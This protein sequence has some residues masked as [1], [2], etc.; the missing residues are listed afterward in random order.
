MSSQEQQEHIENVEYLRG[1][2]QTEIEERS[3]LENFGRMCMNYKPDE[4]PFGFLKR[5]DEFNR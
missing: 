4:S 1:L 2:V 3:S 5:F